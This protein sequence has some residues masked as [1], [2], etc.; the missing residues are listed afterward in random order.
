MIVAPLH[1]KA[2]GGVV[3]VQMVDLAVWDE[4]GA[5]LGYQTGEVVVGRMRNGR[6][7]AAR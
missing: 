7:W 4:A 3:G 5:L 1:R 2:K 6:L